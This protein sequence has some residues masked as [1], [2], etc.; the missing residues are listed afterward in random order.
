MTYVRRCDGEPT[1]WLVAEFITQSSQGMWIASQRDSIAWQPPRA[2]RSFL[3]VGQLHDRVILGEMART[4]ARSGFL[5]HVLADAT[6]PR[7]RVD[8]FGIL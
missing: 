5:S 6:A 7:D 3:D 4:P 8:Q 2:H 1:E